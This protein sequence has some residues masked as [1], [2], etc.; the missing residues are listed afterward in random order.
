MWHRNVIVHTHTHSRADNIII[1]EDHITDDHLVYATLTSWNNEKSF[2]HRNDAHRKMC[3]LEIGYC[4]GCWLLSV[5]IPLRLI[6]C[7]LCKWSAV[8]SHW[9]ALE[10][11][12]SGSSGSE[13]SHS[14]RR[15]VKR[16]MTNGTSHMPRYGTT[17]FSWIFWFRLFVWS[18]FRILFSKF[19]SA[20]QHNSTDLHNRLP[21]ELI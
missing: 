8:R 17:N 4:Y 13:N 20:P 15:N 3:K 1:I 19:N 21:F 16:Q 9:I 11:H 10:P 6:D 14:R 2:G 7:F 5:C 18:F 12:S